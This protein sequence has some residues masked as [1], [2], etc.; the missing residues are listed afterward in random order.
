MPARQGKNPA[1]TQASISFAT[2]STL[3][4]NGFPIRDRGAFRGRGPFPRPASVKTGAW[5]GDVAFTNPLQRPSLLYANVKV[6]K[7]TSGPLP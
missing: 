3:L 4:R 7:T 1:F 6:S 5:D 2:A